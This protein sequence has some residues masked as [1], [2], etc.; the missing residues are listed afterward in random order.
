MVNVK[1]TN[2]VSFGY[3][4]E[5]DTTPSDVELAFVGNGGEILKDLAIVVSGGT[6]VVDSDTGVVTVSPT[7]ASSRVDVIAQRAYPVAE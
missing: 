6:F 2:G 3:T 1:V 7:T 4:F 5:S